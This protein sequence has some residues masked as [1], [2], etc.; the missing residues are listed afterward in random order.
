MTHET[1]L[2]M[3]SCSYFDDCTLTRR[4]QNLFLV[5]RQAVSHWLWIHSWSWP[6][7][8]AAAYEIEQRDGWSNGRSRQRI[9]YRFQALV[10]H[11]FPTLEEVL[12]SFALASRW[13]CVG[14]FSRVACRLLHRELN[15]KAATILHNCTLNGSQFSCWAE[16]TRT[17]PVVKM[18]VYVSFLEEADLSRKCAGKCAG[19]IQLI[20]PNIHIPSHWK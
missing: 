4:V 20:K 19:K 16:M 13:I 6:E 5:W 10:L 9:L 18:F 8:S 17:W 11:S 1:L 2:L 12:S 7:T 14:D 3:Y 15:W